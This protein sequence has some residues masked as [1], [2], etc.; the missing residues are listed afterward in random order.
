[1]ARHAA[2][3]VVG[4]LAV[5]GTARALPYIETG[6]A[7]DR[8]SPQATTG[9]GSLTD[10]HGSLDSLVG[11]TLDIVDAFLFGFAGGGTLEIRATVD[12]TPEL[13]NVAL[14]DGAGADLATGFGSLSASG[15]A[16]GSYIVQVDV[17]IDPGPDPA[18]T[19]LLS[20]PGVSF[21]VPEPGLLSLAV[22]GLAVFARIR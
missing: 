9:T 14:I 5:S 6:D 1:M 8:T 12:G 13:L 21:A 7:G 3:L 11:S 17:P 4:L 15:L 20:G 19:I 22:L 18:Y 2:L 10:I 16:A